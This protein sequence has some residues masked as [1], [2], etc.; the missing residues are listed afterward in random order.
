MDARHDSRNLNNPFDYNPNRTIELFAL[1]PDEYIIA[2]DVACQHEYIDAQFCSNCDYQA[3]RIVAQINRAYQGLNE[4]VAICT[5]CR[6][7][8]SFIFDISNKVYQSWLREQL[9]EHYMQQF[10]G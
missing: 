3:L 6:E 8:Y 4:L 9:G 5:H 10:E 2:Q 1:T 7:R